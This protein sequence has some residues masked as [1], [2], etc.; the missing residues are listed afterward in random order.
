MA[1][2]HQARITAL[3]GAQLQSNPRALRHALRHAFQHLYAIL[4]YLFAIAQ[5]EATIAA[6]R[7]GFDPTLGL[8]HSDK[9]CRPSL[10]SDL[11]EPV[12]PVADRITFEMLRDREFSRGEVIETRQGVCRLGAGLARELGQH[13][14]TLREA[15]GPH[16]ERLAR[17]LLKAP[18]HPL[19]AATAPRRHVRWLSQRRIVPYL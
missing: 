8:M 19:D 6:Q 18:D 9:R 14:P 5:T 11:M 1:R 15:V 17:E 16:A 3:S 7:M 13:S 2:L 10:S 12:R 4:N